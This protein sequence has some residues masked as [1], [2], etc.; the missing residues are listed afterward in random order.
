[1]LFGVSL[2]GVPSKAT[3][4]TIGQLPPQAATA[5]AAALESDSG[6]QATDPG[7]TAAAL[8]ATFRNTPTAPVL[9]YPGD[10]QSA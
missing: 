3:D 9:I 6:L 7:G 5:P 2:D 10:I 1:M 4:L 8:T